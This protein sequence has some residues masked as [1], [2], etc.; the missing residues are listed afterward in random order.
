MAVNPRPGERTEEELKVEK[1]K[2]EQR[3]DEAGNQAG[4]AA[5]K[6]GL[7]E[8]EVNKRVEAARKEEKDKLYPQLQALNDSLKDVQATLAAERKEKDEAKKKADEEAEAKRVAKLSSDE[9]QNEVLTR[10]EEQLREERLARE[11][12]RKELEDRDKKEELRKYRDGLIQAANGEIIPELVIGST[13][14]EIDNAFERAKARYAEYVARAKEEVG[15]GVRRGMP[16][17]T[18]PDT[19]APESIQG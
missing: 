2:V 5:K 3:V 11:A 12:F 17:P 14:E 9:R 18:N 4:D 19:A 7:T 13:K 8:E 1:E 6:E 10:L 15:R 16:G